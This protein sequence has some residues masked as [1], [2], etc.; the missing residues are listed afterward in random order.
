MKEAVIDAI[1]ELRAIHTAVNPRPET[2]KA[3]EEAKREQRVSKA[4]ATKQNRK[5]NFL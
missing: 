4:M 2:F 1:T 5:K 3:A